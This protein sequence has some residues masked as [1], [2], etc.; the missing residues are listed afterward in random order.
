MRIILS[1]VPTPWSDEMCD[2]PGDVIEFSPG[3]FSNFSPLRKTPLIRTI[4]TI[5]KKKKKQKKENK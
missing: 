5:K 1:A 3:Y 2:M 4:I